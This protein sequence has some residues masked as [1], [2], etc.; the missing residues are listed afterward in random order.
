MADFLSLD[1][2]LPAIGETL[3]MVFIS[4]VMSLAIGLPVGVVLLLTERGGLWEKPNL[5]AVLGTV[6]NI[7]RS[8][9]FLILMI[10]IIPFT[11]LLVGTSTGTMA[12][13]VPLTIS[14]IPFVARVVE[15]ALREVDHGLVEAAQSR[16]ATTFNTI[17]KV[18]I[19]ESLP[20]ITSG[21]TLTI[22]NLI[23]YSAM[24]GAIG[25]GGLGDLAIRY[26]YHRYEVG[27]MIVSVVVIIL[28]VQLI[29]MLGNSISISINNKRK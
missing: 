16:G 15:S 11:R 9:P 17:T 12:T 22:I 25:G 8:F 23:G 26:G 2:L 18:L 10:V 6:V 1:L 20:S 4:T 27:I 5:S 19:P 13:V 7:M 3:L 14:A 29:Q 21:I 28:L 24:A